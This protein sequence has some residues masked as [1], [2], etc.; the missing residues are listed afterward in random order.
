M[1]RKV[2]ERNGENKRFEL[3]HGQQRE[4]LLLWR[5]RGDP[6]HRVRRMPRTP[7]QHGGPEGRHNRDN[8]VLLGFVSIRKLL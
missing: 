6:K 3:L 2:R 7:E 8:C 5:L 4:H 1:G